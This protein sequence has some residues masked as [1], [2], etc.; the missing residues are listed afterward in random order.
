MIEKKKGFVVYGKVIGKESNKG[1]AG[2]TV[3]A[4]DKD[5]LFDDRLGSAITDNEGN[6]GMPPDEFMQFNI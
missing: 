2:L 1:I 3:E 4:L 6:N 5:L